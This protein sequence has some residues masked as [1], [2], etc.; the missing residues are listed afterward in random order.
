MFE[1]MQ[2]DDFNLK[3]I[4]KLAQ[5]SE[6]E[7][8]FTMNERTMDERD[9]LENMKGK[10]VVHMNCMAKDDKTGFCFL[11]PFPLVYSC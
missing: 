7:E 9:F 1:L 3:A 2:I 11:N 6:R 8:F 10:G 4:F 5:T